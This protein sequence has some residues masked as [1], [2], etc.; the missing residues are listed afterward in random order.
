MA[1]LAPPWFARRVFNPIAMRFGL[2]GTET[3]T[4]P[5]RR[6]GR[7]LRVPVIP[8]EHAGARYLVSTRGESDWVKNLRAAG[9]GELAR[10]GHTRR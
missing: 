8:V 2:S 7:P 6:T 1:Y 3:V 4:V 9:G 5:G 10:R